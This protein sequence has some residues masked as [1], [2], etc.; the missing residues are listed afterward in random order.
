MGLP[1]AIINKILS[2]LSVLIGKQKAQLLAINRQE[3]LQ[4]DGNDTAMQER[5]EL[6]ETKCTGITECL[7]S[8]A[9]LDNPVG[10][11][12]Y[13]HTKEN[14]LQ[15][16][17]RTAAFG[18]ILIIYE[19][20]PDV[21]IEAAAIA[22]KSG[23]KIRLKGGKE[24][25]QTNQFLTSLWHRALE[26]NG[27]STDWIQYLELNRD[28]LQIYLQEKTA[29]IDLVV[30]RGGA[31]LIRFVKQHAAMPVLVSGR[32]NNFIFIDETAAND[33]IEP[34]IV[35]AKLSH[36]SACNALDKVLVHKNWK[37]NN[38]D[39][40]N[41]IIANLEKE[42]TEVIFLETL[43]ANEP[44]LYEEFLAKKIV[45]AMVADVKEAIGVINKYSGKHS[46]SILS[47]NNLHI[48]NFQQEVD[49]AAVYAN[50]STRFTDG[51]QFGL[52]AELAI[53]TEK[54][55]HRGPMGLQHLVT[56]KWFITGNGQIRN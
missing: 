16:E 3:W 30:P 22:F 44:I 55:H 39:L 19:S 13:T 5:L 34:I 53:S 15:I 12:L 42:N 29:S 37:I 1:V 54:I 7:L 28:E 25:H 41:K 48:Q 4:Y 27:I 36:V 51:G 52:G 23:N 9:A 20:R 2:D 45:F 35:N 50:A 21:T 40:L 47:S 38:E 56:N 11:L 8:V 17:N 24:S 33:I 32:G 14:G 26:Q 10:R 49:C 31:S 6:T 18:T 43:S 46:A